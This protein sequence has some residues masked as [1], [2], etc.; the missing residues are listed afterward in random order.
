MAKVTVITDVQG[1][2]EGLELDG[3]RLSLLDYHVDHDKGEP[4]FVTLRFYAEEVTFRKE[5]N[6][7]TES[8]RG[9]DVSPPPE[10]NAGE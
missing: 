8:E 1:R 7:P 2:M 3:Y 9:E 10:A 4:P 6:A 5:G